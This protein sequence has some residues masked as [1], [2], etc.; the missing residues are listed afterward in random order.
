VV[1]TVLGVATLLLALP[2][3]LTARGGRSALLLLIGASAGFDKLQIGG[4]HLFTGLCLLLPLVRGGS[5]R[6]DLSR[7]GWVAAV[8]VI[9]C[10]T[11][12]A[13]SVPFGTLV[14][15]PAI[16][17]QLLLLAGSAGILAVFLESEETFVVAKG[18]LAAV[19]LAA[20]VALL[21]LTAVVPPNYFQDSSGVLRV[22]SFYREP[23]FMAVYLS[24]GLI[25]AYRLAL[26]RNLQ[27]ALIVIISAPLVLS[28]ARGSWLALLVSSLLVWLSSRL[29]P[30]QR[31]DP[32]HRRR[33]RILS[34]ALGALGLALVVNSSLR[35][36]AVG[37]LAAVF[38]NQSGDLGVSARAGQ[39]TAL[40]ELASQAPWHGLGLSAAGRV[41]GLGEVDY[42]HS[43]NNVATNW[44][45]DWW[46][47]GK[48]LAVPLIAL[49]VGV[50]ALSLRRVPGHILTFLLINSL[51]SNVLMSPISWL[52][53]ALVLAGR[54]NSIVQKGRL[55][56]QDEDEGL[57]LPLHRRPVPVVLKS[58]I[59]GVVS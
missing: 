9:F 24:V 56:N 16:G 57:R 29:G 39:L 26:K 30:A 36:T 17:I 25:L 7:R 53:L 6:L 40:R 59:H 20:I 3:L 21:Q 37:R 5:Q 49:F 2:M 44:L 19:A 43:T 23:D 14:N 33:L 22:H 13:L 18:F 35:T 38:N 45:L 41:I 28:F 48:F 54:Q 47:G 34:L 58:Q 51:V 27:V 52:A 8:L 10:A 15:S 50:A 12:L 1:T 46:I 11:L 4:V 32:L 55:F 42:G 31:R